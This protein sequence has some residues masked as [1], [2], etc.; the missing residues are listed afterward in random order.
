MPE[1]LLSGLTEPQRQA[2]LHTDGPMLVLAGPGSGK[3]R[4][5]THRVARLIEQGLDPRRILALT[6]TNKAAEEMRNRLQSMQIRE[7][8]LIC[9]FHSL[10]VRLLREFAVRAGLPAAF[11]IYDQS[12]QKALLAEVYKTA[13]VDPKDFPPAR[14]LRQIGFLKNHLM[15]P[16]DAAAMGRSDLPAK[17]LEDLYEGYQKRLS[18]AGALDFDD[19]LMKTAALLERDAELAEKLSRRYTHLLVDE[20][21]D[22]NTCQYRIARAL[23]RGHDNLFVTGD[24]DQSI[25]GWRGADIGNILAFERDFPGAPVVRLEENFR[26]S[27]QV[28]KLADELIRANSERKAKRLIP[29][30]PDGARPRLYRYADEGEEA[31]G[32]AAWVRSMHEESGLEYRRIA[33]FY[34]TNAMS[35]AVEEALVQAAVP[36]QIVKGVEFFHRREIKD[37][38]AY[39]R[40]LVNPADEISLLRVINR[41]ARGIGDTTVQKITA[42]AR[43]DGADVGAVLREPARVPGLNAGTVSRINSF[44]ALLGELRRKLDRPAAEIVRDVYLRSGLK[45]LFV[46]EKDTDAQENVEELIRSAVRFDE[47]AAESGSSGLENYLLRVALM[48][49]V[50]AYDEASGAVSLM[51]LHSAKGLE[52]AAVLIIG[53]EDGIIP[54]SRSRESG[55]D[56]EEERRLLFVGMT[57]AE[58]FLALSHASSRASYGGPRAASLSPFVRNLTNVDLVLAPFRHQTFDPDRSRTSGVSESYA[59]L[60]FEGVG[61]A[62]AGAGGFRAGQRVRHPALGTGRIEAFVEGSAGARAVIQFDKGARLVMGL[63]AAKVEPVD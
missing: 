21:Q 33:V 52:F 18:E 58:R 6:F 59:S 24:P 50:D 60:P 11:S 54:H 19:L 53:L 34:R 13:N 29:R 45:D 25:Y 14:I 46:D 27:P 55:R 36:Y 42:Q 35:R 23:S 30:Q 48:S 62:P 32:A 16:A 28:L 2:V 47:E 9:T 31:R 44:A 15:T 5:I 22:T 40:L 61:A 39:L 12:D 41:P 43:A 4:V 20:Y 10:C 38:L 7:G 63:A 49:D 57:R 3:T 8:S 51:T 26:S 37:V 56:L 1:N 17:L